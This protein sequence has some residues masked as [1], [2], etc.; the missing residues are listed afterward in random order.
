MAP[1]VPPLS[2]IRSQLALRAGRFERA[3]DLIVAGLPRQMGDSAGLEAVRKRP[4]SAAKAWPFHR[5][6]TGTCS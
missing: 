1:T 5:R 6:A 2:D 3:R 4:E